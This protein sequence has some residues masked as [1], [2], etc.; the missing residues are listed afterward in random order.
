MFEEEI[1]KL[2]KREGDFLFREGEN[3][4]CEGDFAKLFQLIIM[5]M[6]HPLCLLHKGNFFK[7]V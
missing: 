5:L 6:K 3:I 2:L 1:K 7:K 4:I